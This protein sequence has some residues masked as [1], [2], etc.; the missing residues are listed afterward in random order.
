VH[1][2]SDLAIHPDL[3]RALQEQ[4]FEKLT[5][6][7][8]E[9]LPVLLGD[10]TD[11]LGMAATGTGKTAAF[12]IPLL[13]KL[14][15]KKFKTQA[16][17]LSPTRELAQQIA[18]S[19][20]AM[21]K[22]IGTRAIT[23]YGGVGY[24]DQ[25]RDIKRGAQIVIATPGRLI[26]HID[27]G[28]IDLSAVETLV[29]DEADKM[30]SM[31][32]KE[33]L[34]R[35]LAA[36]QKAKQTCKTWL[37]SATL[38]PELRRVA[39]RYLKDPVRVHINSTEVLSGTVEQTYYLVN[40]EDKPEAI[41]RFLAVAEDF[42]GLIFCQTKVLVSELTNMLRQRGH[43][44]DELHGDKSQNERE[45][46]LKRFRLGK[47]KVLVCTDVAARGLDVR[48]LTHV[49]NYSLPREIDSYVHRIGRTG[50]R[51][52][53]GKALS[54]VTRSH[55]P[56]I[57]RI[58][59]LTGIPLIR[60][61]VPTATEVNQRKIAQITKRFQDVSGH[62]TVLQAL[63]AGGRDVFKTD[64]QLE[65]AAKLIHL[66]FPE[67]LTTETRALDVVP[68]E[69]SQG[70]GRPGKT[71]GPRAYQPN[72]RRREYGAQKPSRF[73]GSYSDND[74]RRGRPQGKPS[75]RSSRA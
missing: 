61:R 21:S 18:D 58:E 33:E 23:I 62:E 75:H 70:Q 7:Q 48:D 57:R 53:S 15:S 55:Y 69:S 27:R 25:I 68:N 54:L 5:P 44:A 10:E 72:E 3:L 22:Y 6:I 49:I 65:I 16:L 45:Q 11:F 66:A 26:D 42:Y 14:D 36:M 63:S 32:F 38:Q 37:F 28:T 59:R 60:G 19:I 50:R 31:G 39:E 1:L 9:A 46:T 12:G 2:F 8:T 67:L 71:R 56:L 17:I 13:A 40:E 64:E 4:G 34:E 47:I 35:I 24:G 52:E 73:G 20:Q 51:G 74:S 43:L 29:L 41:C 30:I